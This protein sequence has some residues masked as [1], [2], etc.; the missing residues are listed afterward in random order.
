MNILEIMNIP[1]YKKGNTIHIKKENRGKFTRSAKEHNMGVQEFATHVLN[2]KDKYSPTLVKR[3]NFAKNSKKFKHAK[4][5]L[6]KKCQGGEILDNPVKIVNSNYLDNFPNLINYYNTENPRVVKDLNE[7]VQ[8]FTEND[9]IFYTPILQ[10]IDG[11][12]KNM[13]ND[14]NIDI[15]IKKQLGKEL[16]PELII[17]S[18]FF[19]AKK[20]NKKYQYVHDKLNE[21]SDEDLIKVL[22][23]DFSDVNS[24]EEIK[25]LIP[26]NINLIEAY[27]V[28]NILKNMEDVQ[29]KRNLRNQLKNINNG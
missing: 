4:G 5:G 13:Q 6:I 29:Y 22:T 10:R 28:Y 7:N 27:K 8:Y 23:T 9:S 11:V 16:Q 15:E 2:N 17:R 24:L 3:A 19:P 25:N 26:E 21:V 12:I 14:K 20:F 18:M 1:Y